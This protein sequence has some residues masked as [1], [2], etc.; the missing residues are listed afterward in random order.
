M[1]QLLSKLPVLIALIAVLAFLAY[2]GTRLGPRFLIRRLAGLVFVIVG[3]TF[4]T[5]I[6]GYLSPVGPEYTQCQAKCTPQLIHEL[7]HFYGLDKPWWTQYFAFL[8]RLLHGSLGLSYTA[9]GQTVLGIMG[10]GVP[11]SA[12]LGLSALVLQLLLGI[13]IG[14][15]AAV[16]AGSKLD[17]ISMSAALILF[18]LPTF[19]LIPFYQLLIVWL[20]AHHI[21]HFGLST[22]VANWGLNISIV[23]PIGILTIVGMGFYARLTRTTMLEVLNQDYIRTAR[24]KG[25]R[26]RVVIVRHAFRNALVPIVT[27]IGPAVAFVVGGAFFTETLFNIPGIGF[28]AV[29]SIGNSDMPVVQGTVLLVAIAVTV[30]NTVVDVVYGLLDP[31]I[32]IS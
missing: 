19:V 29:A 1:Q 31:R 9:K 21:P 30:M 14:I 12:E 7:R 15:F 10:R 5:F 16:R 2:T 20:S 3:V 17:T 26:E 23:A 27:A 18:S 6:L 32:K 4:I 8:N 13:P 24:A 28:W 11:I 22:S 25:L